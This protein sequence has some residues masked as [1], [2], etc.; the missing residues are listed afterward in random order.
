MTHPN[1]PPVVPRFNAWREWK[2]IIS[3]SDTKTWLALH[4]EIRS[5]D[6][7]ELQ[8]A[9]SYC[10]HTGF[11]GIE[12]VLL[13]NFVDTAPARRYPGGLIL[14]P[15]DDVLAAA[16]TTIMPIRV[17]RNEH[18]YDAWFPVPS[19]TPDALRDAIAE[20]DE[21]VTFLARSYRITARWIPKYVETTLQQKAFTTIKESDWER[22]AGA[23]ARWRTLP[24]SVRPATSRSAHWLMRAQQQRS[25]VD[26]FIFTWFALESLL[27][28]LYEHATDVELPLQDSD[29]SLSRSQKRKA[30][31]ARIRQILADTV[32]DDPTRAATDAYFNGVV[33]IRRRSELVLKAA[34]GEDNALVEWP[35]GQ[36]DS[37]ARLRTEIVHNGSSIHEVYERFPVDRIIEKLEVL[38]NEMIV[39]TLRR[40]WRGEP[41]PTSSQTMTMPMHFDTTITNAP[42]G[43]F[44]VQGDFRITHQMLAMKGLL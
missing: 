5:L 28:A 44:I 33:T 31:D 18:I 43:G 39:R 36:S 21:T 30:Q 23:L 40:A 24:R 4:N 3:T 34:L 14:V 13:A 8:A 9:Y 12:F 6:G 38:A 11:E 20:I 37:P 22:H 10:K 32:N 15:C 16:D 35:Y 27:L 1:D 26:R 25:A 17:P 19:T 42:G 7:P 2:P 29:R 41:L